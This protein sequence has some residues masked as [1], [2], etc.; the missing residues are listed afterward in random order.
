MANRTSAGMGIQTDLAR[1]ARIIGTAPAHRGVI[2]AGWRESAEADSG[3]PAV[4]RLLRRRRLPVVAAP[5]IRKSSLVFPGQPR[6]HCG[7]STESM[8]EFDSPGLSVIQFESHFSK[9]CLG[10]K[11][12]IVPATHPSTTSTVTIP[13]GIRP[14]SWCPPRPEPEAAG[15]EAV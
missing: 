4:V 9:R 15:P 12:Q 13:R 10:T 2:A 8:P 1:G 11:S 14:R 5:L 6:W 7:V 3:T